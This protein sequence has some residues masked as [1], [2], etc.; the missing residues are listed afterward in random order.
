GAGQ[1]HERDRAG[2]REP[3]AAARSQVH[4]GRAR[5]QRQ[6]RL[7][8]LRRHAQP[9]RPR[10]LPPGVPGGLRRQVLLSTSPTG[11]SRPT[12]TAR[13]IDMAATT[14]QARSTRSK[15]PR[16]IQESRSDRI[17]TVV[18]YIVLTLLL[19]VILYPLIFI[20]SASISDPDAVS[21]GR[22]WLWPVDINFNGYVT[23]F[24]HKPLV[25]GFA[26]AL[27]YVAVGTTLNLTLTLLAA[28]PLSRRDLVG[29]H[30]FMLLF[31]F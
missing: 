18:N 14:L 23:I 31:V 11:E 25:R 26:N 21:S 7:G 4:H 28:Y 30:W 10:E 24:N 6:R 27:F 15:T 3:R 1:Y 20:A 2:D 16:R 9:D 13:R 19:L 5:H 8:D 17:F 29:R 22:V 12:G